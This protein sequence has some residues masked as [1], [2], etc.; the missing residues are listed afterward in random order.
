MV[1]GLVVVLSPGFVAAVF[2]GEPLNA[3]ERAGV[4]PGIALL[5]ASIRAGRELSMKTAL[6]PVVIVRMPV[7]PAPEDRRTNGRLTEGIDREKRG[8]RETPPVKPIPCARASGWTR[9][10][11][12]A[13]EVL[14]ER[15]AAAISGIDAIP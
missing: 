12:L 15:P 3:R 5:A 11:R 1:H 6:G 9:G 8:L 7:H 2:F 13:R 4:G 10:R 14:S